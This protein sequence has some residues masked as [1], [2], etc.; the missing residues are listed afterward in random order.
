MFCHILQPII[1]VRRFAAKYVANPIS[2]RLHL[3]TE[4]FFA[5]KLHTNLLLAQNLQLFY[6]HMHVT[7]NICSIFQKQTKAKY[8]FANNW[9][10][11]LKIFSN[12]IPLSFVT[13]ETGSSHALVNIYIALNNFGKECYFLYLFLTLHL[14]SRHKIKVNL[15]NL[16]Y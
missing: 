16:K 2:F 15:I 9:N 14:E 5:T 10:T 4:K 13:F 1:K 12:K 11:G 6:S 8:N 3:V 7:W